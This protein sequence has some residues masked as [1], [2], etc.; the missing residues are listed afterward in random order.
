MVLSGNNIS[1]CNH[2]SWII[3][4]NEFSV[5]AHS[6]GAYLEVG[7]HLRIYGSNENI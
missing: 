5:G 7:T 1:F 4:R 3:C 6:R 2:A